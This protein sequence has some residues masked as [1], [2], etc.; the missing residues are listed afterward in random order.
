M[1]E[2]RIIKDYSN[3]EVSNHGNVKNS[4]TGRI[5]VKCNHRN[6]YLVVNLVNEKNY[7]AV[8]IHRLVAIAFIDNPLNEKQVDHID[9]NKTNNCVT[10]L[11]W[12]TNAEN[13][14]NVGLSKN[15]KS[16]IKGI[17]WDKVNKKW[18]VEIR[19]NYKGI[20][21]GRF[22]D[23]EDAKRARINKVAELFGEFVNGCEKL[24]T[25]KLKS[26]VR[27]FKQIDDLLNEINQLI[28]L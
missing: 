21:I 18:M 14:R 11:R 22:L 8:K 2:Y 20:H 7:K 25:I 28:H 15:N 6:G 16:G 5:L 17:S 26:P 4:K 1:E 19:Y 23:L 13:Q 3:Y 10:N 24:P 27:L 12:C 9:N